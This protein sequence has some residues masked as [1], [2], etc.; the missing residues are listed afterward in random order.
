MVIHRGAVSRGAARRGAVSRGAVS[1]GAASKGAASRDAASRGAVSWGA[2][3]R[4]VVSS[5]AASRG[6]VCRSAFYWVIHYNYDGKFWRKIYF[7]SPSGSVT[8]IRKAHH[9]HTHTPGTSF[10]RRPFTHSQGPSLIRQ[11]LHSSAR[12][13]P[14]PPP[15]GS[16]PV[17][18]WTP[19][20]RQAA[21]T[22]ATRAAVSQPSA[23]EAG[24]METLPYLYL[25]TL[26]NEWHLRTS[27]SLN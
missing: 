21:V 23:G 10:I 17:Q 19:D 18:Q 22:A 3:S 6:A 2:E 4:G 25:W 9:T 1:R 26:A 7:I 16:R 15:T 27:T 20:V 8:L 12:I 5:G 24:V 11:A 14:K 13:I